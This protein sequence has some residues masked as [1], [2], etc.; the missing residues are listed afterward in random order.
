MPTMAKQLLTVAAAAAGPG[1]PTIVPQGRL[2]YM[3][4]GRK[5]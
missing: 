3:V 5:N 4:T 2:Y 1:G